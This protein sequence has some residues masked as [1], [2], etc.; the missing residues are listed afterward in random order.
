MPFS[1][2]AFLYLAGVTLIYYLFHR[3]M[4]PYVLLAASLCYIYYLSPRAC[5]I[6]SVSALLVWGL[7]LLIAALKQKS[8][9][10]AAK[11]VATAGVILCILTLLLFKYA[12]ALLPMLSGGAAANERLLAFFLLPLGF[13]YYVFQAISYL[14]DLYRDTCET[15]K[16]PFLFLLYLGFFPKFVSGPIERPK[17]LLVQLKNLPQLRL[18]NEERLSKALA[19]LLYGYFMK[20]VV[21]DRL[22]LFTVPTF[23]A[24]LWHSTTGLL[25][26]VFFYSFQLYCDFAGYSAIAVGTARIFGVELT[27]NF[28]APYLSLGITEFWRR[29]H[30]S[31]S[32]FLRDYVYI[33]LGGNRKGTARKCL[34][35][36]VVFF[37]CGM[38]HGNSPTFLIWGMLHGIY[39]VI[40]TLLR[41]KDKQPGILWQIAG[42][43]LTFLA[44]AFAWFFFGI[45]DM[46]L[47]PGY[48]QRM[49][50]ATAPG[51]TFEAELTE[52][53]MGTAQFILAWVFLILVILFDVLIYRGGQPLAET[54]WH[55]HYVP[56][57]ILF[58]VLIMIIIIFG[59]YGGTFEP[60]AF[61][62]MDF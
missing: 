32:S 60:A 23:E 44:V 24:P 26:N 57:Y 59:I 10:R 29:W 38:W 4:R 21:A 47:I 58:Y 1:L 14:V 42:R 40:E 13:S 49:L 28:N 55:W 35:T 46:A 22:A 18:L 27:Q 36:L 8:R 30:R 7:G 37:L 2:F 43:I 41:K 3:S 56:R 12:A 11:G 45:P 53:G 39:S 52:I 25:L 33:P 62:Y 19:D 6:L 20:V 17:E 48:V 9:Q 34:H 50:T 54:V 51:Y 61:M 5:V 15:E 31:L 16:N